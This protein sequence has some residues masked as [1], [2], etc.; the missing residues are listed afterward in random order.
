MAMATAAV[1]PMDA[2]AVGAALL[3]PDAVG[4]AAM[5]PT[6]QQRRQQREQA[7]RERYPGGIP[8][9]ASSDSSSD[10]EAASAARS[11]AAPPPRQPTPPPPPPPTSS[12]CAP[13]HACAFPFLAACAMIAVALAGGPASARSSHARE[14][15][16][17][18]S[19]CLH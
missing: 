18:T 11:G 7:L 19:S 2:E 15:P 8:L 10:D 5:S 13:P 6:R 16:D 3:A 17:C 4:E 9:D 14:A 1:E 12:W